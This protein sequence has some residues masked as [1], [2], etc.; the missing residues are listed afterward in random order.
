MRWNGCGMG[1]RSATSSRTPPS[2]PSRPARGVGPKC[3]ARGRRRPDV[4]GGARLASCAGLLRQTIRLLRPR[5]SPT[6]ANQPDS[7]A[8]GA[9]VL[10]ARSAPNTS[11]LRSG[12]PCFSAAD[13]SG[14][15]RLITK[16][17]SARSFTP[18][19]TQNGLKAELRAKTASVLP[20]E[21]NRTP[22]SPRRLFVVLADS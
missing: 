16:A 14:S 22:L 10:A 1:I 21:A 3:G 19:T 9:D 5:Q 8:R 15:Q 7:S 13:L 6:A 11:G 20:S 2:S 18:Q 12:R 4:F 17:A